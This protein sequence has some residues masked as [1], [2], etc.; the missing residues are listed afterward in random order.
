[1]IWVN[2]DIEAFGYPTEEE[3]LKEACEMQEEEQREEM[4]ECKK[5]SDRTE[6]WNVIYPFMEWLQEQGIVLSKYY[7]DQEGDSYE[8]LQPISKNI[9]T[10]LYEYFNVDPTKLEKERRELL[11]TLGKGE[12]KK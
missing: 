5:L 12:E 9:D 2:N 4:S 1:M 3:A 7:T 8:H 6:D 11:A 10:L